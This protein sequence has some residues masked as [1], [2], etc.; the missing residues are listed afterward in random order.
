MALLT[1]LQETVFPALMMTFSNL[2]QPVPGTPST[3]GPLGPPST[4]ITLTNPAAGSVWHSLQ[5]T[6]FPALMMTFPI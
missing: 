5:E 4:P 6:V 1:A 3:P 2:E